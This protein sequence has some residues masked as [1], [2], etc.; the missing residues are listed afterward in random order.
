M[1]SPLCV[2]AAY[3]NSA[4]LGE[5]RYGIG[6]VGGAIIDEGKGSKKDRESGCGQA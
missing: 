6:D 2:S 1:L 5:F 4:K 3:R